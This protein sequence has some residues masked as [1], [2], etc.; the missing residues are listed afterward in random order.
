MNK[1]TVIGA[2]LAG[3]EAAYALANE[4]IKVCLCEQ[5]PN[6]RSAAHH[7]DLFAE[8]V[9]SN[10][11]KADRISSAGGLLKSEM[12][13][14][15]SLC[16]ESA[17]LNRVPAGGALAVERYG[18]AEYITEKIKSHKNIEIAYGEITQIPKE[19][20]VIIA[21]GPLTSDAL[22]ESIRRI[23]G[24]SLS[25]YDAAAP[26]VTAES[27]DKDECFSQS[28]YERG[29]E[30]DYINCP[31]NK[32]QY[33]AFYQKT[34]EGIVIAFSQA[35]T[36]KM[37]TEREKSFGNK[38]EFYTKELIF[39]T[40]SQKLEMISLLSP[41]GALYENEKRTILGLS[42]DP[43]LEGVRLMSLNWINAKNAD[44]YQV[45]NVNVDVVDE[46]KEKKK[47]NII[48]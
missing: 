48:Y 39:M 42:P 22:F 33:E 2:G 21:S 13:R 35:F 12:R 29:N 30:D 23:C 40:M 24:D 43:E 19:G 46:E 18:F 17:D 38:I 6:R 5:K 3:C 25:F 45:G 7:T 16:L 32:E 9:C 1:V 14:F 36:K 11:L 37:F 4:G 28:R 41:T 26:I 20:T 47:K 34:I 44:L 10:S 15:G 27:L 31:L 8:L